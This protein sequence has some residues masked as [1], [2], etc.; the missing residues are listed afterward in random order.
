MCAFHHDTHT[1]QCAGGMLASGGKQKRF[2]TCSS[3]SLPPYSEQVTFNRETHRYTNQCNSTKTKAFI[4]SSQ[5][6]NTLV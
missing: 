6:F 2:G 4:L 3:V 5:L 1:Y